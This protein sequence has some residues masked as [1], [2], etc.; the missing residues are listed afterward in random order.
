MPKFLVPTDFSAGS[1]VAARFAA[2][3]ADALGLGVE[4]L[5]AYQVGRPAGSLINVEEHMEAGVRND[6]DVFHEQLLASVPAKVNLSK[7]SMKKSAV[8]A[9]EY[10]TNLEG[11]EVSCIVMGTHGQTALEQIFVGS[12]TRK[13]I[14]AVSHPVLAVPPNVEQ[15]EA[16]PRKVLWAL[17]ARTSADDIGVRLV[18]DLVSLPGGK[19]TFFYAG[20]D[21]NEA[22]AQADLLAG[23]IEHNLYTTDPDGEAG[24]QIAEA[25]RETGAELL[26]MT[27][28]ERGLIAS[29]LGGSTTAKMLRNTQV[30]VLVLHP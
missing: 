22:G 19:L 10:I 29:W 5:H 26:V 20:T 18:K 2:K 7:R 28:R 30:P 1:A 11:D 3:L 9:I 25:V 4:L 24:E 15:M 8:D 23:D 13:V 6:F 16:A 12:T 21:A 14:E 27:H 17:D